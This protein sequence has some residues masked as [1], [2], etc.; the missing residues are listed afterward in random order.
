MLRIL[1]PWR[2]QNARVRRL[3]EA[4]KEASSQPWETAAAF[5][6]Q[7]FPTGSGTT[8][9]PSRKIESAETCFPSRPIPREISVEGE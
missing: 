5:E 4:G 6:I 2:A 7:N 3:Y 8:Q 9:A 1:S